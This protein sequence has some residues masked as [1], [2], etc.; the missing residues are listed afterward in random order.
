M[1][2]FNTQEKIAALLQPS[3]LKKINLQDLW[4]HDKETIS[5][6]IVRALLLFASL[7]SLEYVFMFH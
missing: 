1:N 3:Y 2:Y 5:A 4:A 7:L 6:Q